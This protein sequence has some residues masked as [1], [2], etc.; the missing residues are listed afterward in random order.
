VYDTKLILVFWWHVC[1][2]GKPLQLPKTKSSV[3]CRCNNRSRNAVENSQHLADFFQSVRPTYGSIGRERW[4]L[5]QLHWCDRALAPDPPPSGNQNDRVDARKLAEL[6]QNNQLR[7]VT[8]GEQET[9]DLETPLST[10]RFAADR[11]PRVS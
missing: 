11:R 5:G 2:P 10:K 6:L 9:R 4:N 1:L 3:G 7:P 8:G